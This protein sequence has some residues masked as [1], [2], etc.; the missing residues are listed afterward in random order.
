MTDCDRFGRGRGPGAVDQLN[1]S[2]DTKGR[3][4]ECD[5]TY[6]N[7]GASSDRE[8]PGVFATAKGYGTQD[9]AE[10]TKGG[11]PALGRCDPDS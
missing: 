8:E 5:H 4:H 1:G 7:D 2:Y 10:P 3:K 11:A 6:A 9:A